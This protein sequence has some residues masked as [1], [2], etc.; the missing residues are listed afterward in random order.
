MKEKE[1]FPP[2]FVVIATSQ[3]HCICASTSIE[4]GNEDFEV[5]LVE[6]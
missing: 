2:E 5:D 6:F 1:Y 4:T 3:C